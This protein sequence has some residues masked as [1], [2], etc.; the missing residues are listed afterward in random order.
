QLWTNLVQA[1]SA[2]KDVV[3]WTQADLANNF[4]AGHLAMVV[5]GPWNFNIFKQAAATNHLN[6]GVAPIPV[7]KAGAKDVVPLGGEVWTIPASSNPNVEQKAWQVLSC[8]QQPANML[9][10]DRV[11]Y[12]SPKKAVA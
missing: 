9:T 12:V 3:T 11:G 10:W 8:M 7:P 6:W 5:N 4:A 1:G 2:P